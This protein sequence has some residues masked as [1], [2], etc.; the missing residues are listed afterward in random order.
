MYP[1]TITDTHLRAGCQNHTFA[2]WRA[3]SGKEVAAM[4]GKKATEF[5]PV[6]IGLIDLLC[7]DREVASV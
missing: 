2:E 1:V 5:Y 4:D 6:L 3:L 7:K